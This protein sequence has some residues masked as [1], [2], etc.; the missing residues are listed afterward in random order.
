MLLNRDKFIMEQLLETTRACELMY[1]LYE[2]MDEETEI[3]KQ[4]FL[5]T[6]S[7]MKICYEIK[8]DTSI[9]LKVEIYLSR[10]DKDKKYEVII[11]DN[12]VS[13]IE[14]KK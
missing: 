10:Y 3:N 4:S 12:K 5:N 2:H 13:Y 11:R 9:S 6:L 1:L 8:Y 14:Q 7:T